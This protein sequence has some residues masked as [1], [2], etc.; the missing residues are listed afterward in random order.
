VLRSARI[1]LKQHRF[2]VGAGALA[3]VLVGVAALWVN[4]KL[5]ALNV[6]AACFEA[7]MGSGGQ[8]SPDCDRLV[9]AFATIVNEEAAKLFAAMAVLPIAA[10]LLAGVTL[11]G[12]ELESRTAQ[13]AW[14]LAASRRR[15]FVRQVWPVVLVLG[16]T[17]AFAAFAVS[18][19]ETTLATFSTYI[20][21]DL[22]LYGPLV[23]ARAFGAL[24]LGLLVGAAVGRTLPAFVLAAVLSVVLVGIGSPGSR[25]WWVNAQPRV[26]VDQGEG[27]DGR[28]FDGIMF[29]QVWRAPAGNL[30]SENDVYTVVPADRSADAYDWLIGA[31]YRPVQLGITAETARGWEP[32][33]I[34]GSVLIGLVF[35]LGAVVVVERRRPT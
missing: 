22:G 8:V 7:W 26:V 18:A 34:A 12:R 10:G 19:L 29:E 28:G 11:V 31:G 1:T 21:K 2:E 32:L 15:W 3:A 14:A 4:S 9:S 30:I 24:G 35:V 27:N 13:T 23:V 17:V 16:V 5:Q 20:W 6:P 33:E 25:A